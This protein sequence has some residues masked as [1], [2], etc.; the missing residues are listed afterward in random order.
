M[1]FI[2]DN[3][4]WIAL[5]ITSGVLL[6]MPALQARGL[7]PTQAVQMINRDKAMVVDVCSPDEFKAGHIVGARNVPLGE[8]ESKLPNVVKNKAV[9]VIFACQTGMRSGRAVAMAKKLGYEQA[10]SLGGGLKSWKEANLPV[11]T[12]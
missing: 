8:L 9:P 11:E 10:Q 1:N 2:L 3:W 6:V 5:A 4:M 7:T 12:A